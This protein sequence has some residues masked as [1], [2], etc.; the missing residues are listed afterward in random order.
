MHSGIPFFLQRIHRALQSDK[1]T[2][3]LDHFPVHTRPPDSGCKIRRR[4]NAVDHPADL[5]TGQNIGVV[6][7]DEETASGT[8]SAPPSVKT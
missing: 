2:I 6:S 3:I 7:I 5:R 1:F 8:R 4:A